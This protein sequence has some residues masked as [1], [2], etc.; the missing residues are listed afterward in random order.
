MEQYLNPD[1]Q[2]DLKGMLYSYLKDKAQRRAGVTSKSD[3]EG[4][5]DQFVKQMRL[6]DMGGLA[7]GL[8][9]AASMAGT[10]GGKR[11]KSDIIPDLNKDLYGSS[12]GAYENFRTLRD[13]EERSNM[14]DLNVARYLTGVE[15]ASDADKMNRRRQDFTEKQYAEQAPNRDLQRQMLQ[16]NLMAKKLQPNLQWEDGSPV[17]MGPEGPQRLPTGIK[18]RDTKDD[19]NADLKRALLEANID[20]TRAQTGVNSARMAQ[21]GKE[22]SEG[23]RMSESATMRVSEARDAF[24]S[25]DMLDSAMEKWEPMM[26]PVEGRFRSINPY[27][28]EAQKFDSD[29]RRTAQTIGKYMEGGVLRKEDEEKYRRMLPALSDTPQVARYKLQQTKDMLKEKQA[30]DLQALSDQGYRTEGLNI[31]ERSRMRGPE[32]GASP[33]IGEVRKG[34]RYIGGNPAQKSSW[35]KAQ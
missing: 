14:N 13:M 19:P 2:N 21:I 34:Y 24:A 18:Y 9:E 16:Q 12:Q 29:L 33:Q 35:E 6:R 11:A 1:D 20:R 23:K 17:V 28:T 8:S 10:L 4:A 22:G 25:V 30:R 26:G 7:G 5:E 32:I 3:Y 31:Q 15:Q 27:D